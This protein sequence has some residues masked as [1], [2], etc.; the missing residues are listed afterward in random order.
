M[1]NAG[2][3]LQE[4]RRVPAKIDIT[5]VV[6]CSTSQRRNM[7]SSKKELT[8]ESPGNWSQICQMRLDEPERVEGAGA[9]TA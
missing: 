2:N 5:N 6:F 9:E 7:E 1:R 3:P 8:K 4:T